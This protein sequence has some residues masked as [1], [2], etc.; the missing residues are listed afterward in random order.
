MNIGNLFS[1]D[2]LGYLDNE[3]SQCVYYS[4][5]TS[6]SADI[7]IRIADMGTPDAI[8]LQPEQALKLL[9]WLEKERGTLETL[10]R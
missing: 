5:S 7:Q 8:L 2:R 6:D 10:T 3:K 9:A 4:Q 1:R